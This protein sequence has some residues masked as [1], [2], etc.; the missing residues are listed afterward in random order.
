[1]ADQ[2]HLRAKIQINLFSN[3]SALLL[4]VQSV[5]KQVKLAQT[6]QYHTKSQISVVDH[7]F[8]ES[9]TES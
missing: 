1:M 3:I 8:C 7:F 9:E 2:G 6:E 4:I 5:F